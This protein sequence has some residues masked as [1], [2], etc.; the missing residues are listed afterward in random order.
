[1]TK[2]RT[3]HGATDNVTPLTDLDRKPDRDGSMTPGR[4]RLLLASGLLGLAGAAVGLVIA[5]LF[6]WSW[7]AAAA[8]CR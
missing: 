8:L 3:T 1:M 7:M 6:Q 5:L 4:R 2:H